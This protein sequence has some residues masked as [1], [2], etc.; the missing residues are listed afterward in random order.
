LI[1]HLICGENIVVDEGNIDILEQLVQDLG[2][3]ELS[4]SVLESIEKGETL[5]INNCIFRI[6]RRLN[7]GIEI[8]RECEFIGSHFFEME[9]EMIRKLDIWIVKDIF[10]SNS[11]QIQNEDWFLDFIL[12]LGPPAS[13]LKLLGSVH[14][15]YLS[16]SS[17]DFFFDSINFEDINADIWH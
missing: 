9:V 14:F 2:N 16:C 13:Y 3:P 15:E 10:D 12:T 8:N 5:N 6:N 17:I 7:L 1:S 4:E 11:F